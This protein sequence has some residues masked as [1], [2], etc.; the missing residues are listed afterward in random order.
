[1]CLK[2]RLGKGE[3][4]EGSWVIDYNKYLL[5]MDSSQWSLT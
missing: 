1:M 5:Q 2:D 4:V 3:N